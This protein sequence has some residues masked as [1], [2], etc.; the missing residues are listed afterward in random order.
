[1]KKTRKLLF[2][3]F[4]LSFAMLTT[5]ITAYATDDNS[6]R[7]ENNQA[8]LETRDEE[9]SKAV[10]IKLYVPNL[11]ENERLQVSKGSS[12]DMYGID[13]MTYY[14][15]SSEIISVHEYL[16]NDMV[17]NYNSMQLGNQDVTIVID[18]ATTVL[19]ICVIDGQAP[20]EIK[21]IKVSE[22]YENYVVP[23]N[24]DIT[25]IG[26]PYFHTYDAL[27]RETVGTVSGRR[28]SLDMMSDFDTS[29][30]GEQI[31]TIDFNGVKTTFVMN[32]VKPIVKTE[33]QT[34][35][36]GDKID[37]NK[38]F[39]L[40]DEKNDKNVIVDGWLWEIRDAN[41]QDTWIAPYDTSKAGT[42]EVK[43]GFSV[44]GQKYEGIIR[45]NVVSKDEDSSIIV[46]PEE[47]N[48]IDKDDSTSSKSEVT[49][50]PKTGDESNV[51][52][53]SGLLLCCLSSYY[54]LKKKAD[55]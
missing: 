48:P 25:K 49:K 50:T 24:V 10:S 32:V 42:Q 55:C 11:Q 12:L 26:L 47:N 6:K 33:E 29:K 15:E 34:L 19:P 7:N 41:M 53:Y 5:T 36:I 37:F 43:F 35:K 51:I 30:L 27:G 40:V 52:M 31:V 28:T 1:M 45:V 21:S 38:E 14:T 44:F 46:K 3:T 54:I 18:G 2:A 4:S 17:I 13:Y 8:V 23:Y 9:K 39:V 22:E 20:G 16:T